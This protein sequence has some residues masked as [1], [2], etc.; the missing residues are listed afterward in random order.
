MIIYCIIYGS[1]LQGSAYAFT[2]PTPDDSM[3]LDPAP[4]TLP[5]SPPSPQHP[6][7]PSPPPSPT[8][9]ADEDLDASFDLGHRNLDVQQSV[10]I[11]EE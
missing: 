10:P 1:L 3:D 9:D 4:P 11:H 6:R 7:S 5:R 8:P 2:L